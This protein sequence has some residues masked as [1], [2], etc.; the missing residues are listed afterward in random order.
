M[1]DIIFLVLCAV[2]ASILLGI[3]LSRNTIGKRILGLDKPE[4]EITYSKK[5]Y[6]QKTA[7][8]GWVVITACAALL[9]MQLLIAT[10]AA[11]QG[12]QAFYGD[13][14]EWL[15]IGLVASLAAW[16]GLLMRYLSIKPRVSTISIQ[17]KD[18]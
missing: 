8:G 10:A 13:S 1:L 18:I 15:L 3:L 6:K 5:A 9:C 4:I 14:K 17:A 7:L 12:L 2:L 16:S 11:P